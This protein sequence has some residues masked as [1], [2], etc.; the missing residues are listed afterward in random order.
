MNYLD[1]VNNTVSQ[2]SSSAKSQML[3]YRVNQSEP[4]GNIVEG[5]SDNDWIACPG[6]KLLLL[7]R[8]MEIENMLLIVCI[9]TDS[10]QLS[11]DT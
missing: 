7:L 10:A 1:S 8:E 4:T 6:E 3:A 9:W 2:M 5:E 11:G